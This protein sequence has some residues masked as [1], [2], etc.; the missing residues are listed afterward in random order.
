MVE[1][2]NAFPD[3][4]LPDQNGDVR[5]LG[6]YAGKWL[7]VYFYPRD[8]TSGCSLEA[9]QFAAMLQKRAAKDTVVVGVSADSAASHAKFAAKLDLPFALL[10]DSRHEL[11][12][13]A[14]VWAKKKMAGR[15]YMGIVRSTYLVDPQGVVRASWT[16]VKADGH[17][18]EVLNALSA[19]QGQ[20]I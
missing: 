20:R 13:A 4:S 3:F 1:V 7:V 5:T 8:N 11:L 17:A 18:E 6:E 19:L 14:G 16:K 12:K 10:S 2:G 9:T 15:E